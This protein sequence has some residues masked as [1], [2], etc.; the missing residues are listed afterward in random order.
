MKLNNNNTN[1][2]K[3]IFK[4]HIIDSLFL[5]LCAD[6]SIRLILLI[7]ELT[8]YCVSFPVPIMYSSLLVILKNSFSVL[9]LVGLIS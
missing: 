8:E 4:I 2:N 6:F 3:K 1:N 9:Y 7:F 5:T